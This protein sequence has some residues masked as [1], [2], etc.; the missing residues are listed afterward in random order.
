MPIIP[1]FCFTCGSVFSS[2]I[3]VEN[4]TVNLEGNVAGPCP[5]CGGMGGV[6]D[7]HMRVTDSVIEL[8]SGPELSIK[9]LRQLA[10]TI[11]SAKTN[12]I[13]PNKAI[14]N[15]KEAAP[16][17]RSVIDALPKN[18]IELY[19]FLT[20]IATIISTLIGLYVATKDEPIKK[21][22]IKSM[23]DR[24]IAEQHP[25]NVP[26]VAPERP[27]RNDPCTCGSG[28]KY[29]NCCGGWI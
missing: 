10:S 20:L 12:P 18:R 3:Y 9:R 28:K 15:L 6:L 17:L 29:K 11:A 4:S 23:I 8:L 26:Y 27:G 22:E 1:A 5:K 13:A 16:E 14:E 24:S 25:N 7:G 2:G 21:D 19:A